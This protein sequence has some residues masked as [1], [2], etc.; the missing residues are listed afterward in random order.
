[1]MFSGI[2]L[3]EFAK[4]ITSSLGGML[5]PI[6]ML[7]AGIVASNIDFKKTLSDKRIYRVLA[8]RM[9]I[10]PIII[11]GILKLLA[12]IPIVDV[13]KVLLISFLASITPA[14][15]T[16][17][18]LAQIHNQDAEYATAINILTTVICILTMP[19]FVMVFEVLL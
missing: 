6:A 7:I 9:V 3:P 4:D 14:A 19:L 13:D 5:G 2:R 17:M 1:M 16:V 11:L 8:A 18:Q 12:F 10:Y 15:S